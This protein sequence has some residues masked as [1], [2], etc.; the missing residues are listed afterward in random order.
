[1]E[2]PSRDPVKGSRKV[3]LGDG[4]G[5]C[6]IYDGEQ[7]VAGCRIDGPAIIERVDTTI[8]IPSGKRGSVDHYGNVLIQGENTCLTWT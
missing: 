1:M 2:K 3:Y 6:P 5:D 8:V 4:W 7:L